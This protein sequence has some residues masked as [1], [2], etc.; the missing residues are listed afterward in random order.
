MTR[1]SLLLAPKRT[2]G[3]FMSLYTGG[4]GLK[5]GEDTDALPSFR[6][7]V[8]NIFFFFYRKHHLDVIPINFLRRRQQQQRWRHRFFFFAC[9]KIRFA[10]ARRASFHRKREIYTNHYSFSLYLCEDHIK[11]SGRIVRALGRWLALGTRSVSG[12]SAH[13]HSTTSSFFGLLFY[14]IVYVRP[15]KRE[16]TQR[17]RRFGSVNNSVR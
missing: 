15:I 17:E 16:E 10:A 14:D 13:R 6:D 11:K 4:K 1:A 3:S 12:R 2:R 5:M 7:H 9:R 8:P